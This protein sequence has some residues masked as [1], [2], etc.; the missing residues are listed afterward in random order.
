MM[1]A[2]F[3]AAFLQA[4][5]GFGFALV[6][7]PL[8]TFALG[9]E[10]AVPLVAGVALAV[11]CANSVRLRRSI[12]RRELAALVGAALLGVPLG[13]WLF[14]HVPAAWVRTSLGAVLIAY[15]LYAWLRPAHLPRP[16]VYWALPAGFLAGALGGAYNVPGPPVIVYGDLCAWSRNCYRATLQ[17]FFFI[18]GL[19]VVGGH[20]L[21]GRY[22]R[23]TGLLLLLAAP[24]LV[25]GN[26][27]GVWADRFIDQR[28]FRQ[29]VLW[30]ILATGVMLLF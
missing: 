5:T 9:L 19:V 6:A 20:A 12:E 21:L 17:A 1:I 8:V 3:A 11:T 27:A 22:D 15:A 28:R 29:I 7:M 14:A 18:T 2:V 24:A 10:Q 13:F 25:A 26:A 23:S 4:T 30:L 16:G